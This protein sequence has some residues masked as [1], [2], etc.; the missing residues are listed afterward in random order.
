M[1]LIFRL[2]P[3]VS[4]AASPVLREKLVMRSRDRAK[5]GTWTE[6]KALA[7]QPRS[8]T[9]KKNA[10]S[11]EAAFTHAVAARTAQGSIYPVD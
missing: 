4:I 11:E 1:T 9:T 8:L 5:W 2:Y 10:A 6:S 7:Q 3:C